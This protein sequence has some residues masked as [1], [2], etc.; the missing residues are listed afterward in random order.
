MIISDL[1]YLESVSEAELDECNGSAGA[2]VG[3]WGLAL[4]Q[5]SKTWTNT[6][7]FSKVFPNGSSI[8]FG[9]GVV[10]VFAFTPAP[11]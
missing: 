5:Y 11:T 10:G 7:T 8:A 6:R 4:G 3:V 2:L 9:F 1:G